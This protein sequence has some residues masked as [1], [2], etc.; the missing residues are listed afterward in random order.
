M[1]R[2]ALWRAGRPGLPQRW[3]ALAADAA[4][5]RHCLGAA[6]QITPALALA[7]AA[8]DAAPTPFE[9][10]EEAG[11][12]RPSSASRSLPPE[13]AAPALA[14]ASPPAMRSS[15]RRSLPSSGTSRSTAFRAAASR[16]ARAGS[17]RRQGASDASKEQL[18]RAECAAGHAHTQTASCR[19]AGGRPR[20]ATNRFRASTRGRTPFRL[21]P[22]ARGGGARSGRAVATEP[23]ATRS[24]R[25]CRE[26]AAA[27]AT[28]PKTAMPLSASPRRWV[29]LALRA[30]CP[31]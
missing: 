19:H 22:R 27:G 7:A 5:G 2:G 8:A 11:V 25:P 16:A 17:A 9:G 31:G 21:R 1:I 13:L 15:A 20:G 24:K 10:E 30:G 3:D 26:R 14:E 6:S 4:Q 23:N 18:A 12:G 29:R 28:A